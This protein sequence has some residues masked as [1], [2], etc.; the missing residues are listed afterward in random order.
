MEMISSVRIAIGVSMPPSRRR[1][2]AEGLL[3]DKVPAIMPPSLVVT[4]T[5]SFLSSICGENPNSRLLTSLSNPAIT[6]ST[7]MSTIT[8]TAT[9]RRHTRVI[10]EKYV[11]FGL[12]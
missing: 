3:S 9:P 5:P 8:P 7:T 10:S 6:A 1:E 4:I 11:R 2:I 12:R